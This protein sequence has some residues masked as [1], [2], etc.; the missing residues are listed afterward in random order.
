MAEKTGVGAGHS[1]GHVVLAQ[2]WDS[3]HGPKKY[4]RGMKRVIKEKKEVIEV[5]E[6]RSDKKMGRG[7]GDYRSL[8][9]G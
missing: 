8:L 3:A 7:V 4:Q 9:V 2:Q 6:E 1:K 5:K